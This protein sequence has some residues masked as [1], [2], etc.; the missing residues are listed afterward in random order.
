MIKLTIVEKADAEN[1]HRLRTD[2]DVA[3][4]IVRDLDV[5]IP[6]IERFIVERLSDRQNILF[7]KIEV[8]P[9]CELAGTI[10]LKNFGLHPKYA[11]IGYELF[12]K[13]HGRGIMKTALSEIVGLAFGKLGLE[14]LESFTHRDN[15]RSRKL[16]ERF[17]FAI[18]QKTDKNNPDN[19]IYQLTK[20]GANK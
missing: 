20:N 8:L 10:V 6:D 18:T 14:Q 16:L 15:V 3:R 12:P 2:A 11:E 1:I 5:T 9:D 7:Y 19:V 17:G 4:F 13:F